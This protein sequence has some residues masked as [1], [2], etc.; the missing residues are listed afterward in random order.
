M[1][2]VDPK[3]LLI[4][5]KLQEFKQLLIKEIQVQVKDKKLDNNQILNLNL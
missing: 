2:L 5:S 1:D 3:L 4:N